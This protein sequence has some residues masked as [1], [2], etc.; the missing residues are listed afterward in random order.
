MAC[1]FFYNNALKELL[2]TVDSLNNKEADKGL[3]GI[4][5]LRNVSKHIPY[6]I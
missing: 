5:D 6:K 3:F 4:A 2:Y 1:L